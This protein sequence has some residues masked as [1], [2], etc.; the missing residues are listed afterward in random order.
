[1]EGFKKKTLIHKQIQLIQPL[2][3]QYFGKT[4]RKP[5]L[6]ELHP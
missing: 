5:S 4:V 6:H 3:A 2:E 1:M